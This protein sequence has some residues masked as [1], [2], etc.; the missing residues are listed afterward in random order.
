M[1]QCSTVHA[2]A[3]ELCQC[4]TIGSPLRKVFRGRQ[5]IGINP[6]RQAAAR[7]GR[8]FIG[9]LSARETFLEGDPIMGKLLMEPAI[10]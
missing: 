9:K 8:I 6:P 4:P 10:F 2:G 1:L 5:F 7:A 3:S